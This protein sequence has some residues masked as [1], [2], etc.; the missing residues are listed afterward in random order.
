[1]AEL[2]EREGICRLST[3]LLQSSCFNPSRWASDERL[4]PGPACLEWLRVRWRQ[5]GGDI[6]AAAA[7][8]SCLGPHWACGHSLSAAGAAMDHP[9]TATN[10]MRRLGLRPSRPST[11]H[12]SGLHLPKAEIDWSLIP[13]SPQHPWLLAATPV[14]SP[15]PAHL[16]RPR[17]ASA[18]CAPPASSL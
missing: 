6:F 18:P 12:G 17:H 15:G 11:K 2:L 9:P 10:L 7:L 14:P 13:F 4:C 5:Q 1:M 16:S 3:R 8:N